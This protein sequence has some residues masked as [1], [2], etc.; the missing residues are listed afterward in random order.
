MSLPPEAKC[1]MNLMLHSLDGQPVRP[2]HL[3]DSAFAILVL[4][5]SEMADIEHR[6]ELI[7]T[8]TNAVADRV[9]SLIDQKAED[10]RQGAALN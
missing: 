10:E 4:S 3:A 1:W 8:L 7:N 6:H 2:R 9:K 5:L